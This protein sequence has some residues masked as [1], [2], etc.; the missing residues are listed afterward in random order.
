MIDVK[1]IRERKIVQAAIAYSAA[2][3]ALLQV[4]EFLSGTYGWPPA[5]LRG[6]PVL[7]VAG[8][9]IVIVLAWF[10]GERGQQRVTT[11][12]A[13]I[14]AAL[15]FIG[16]G[17]S[18]L[19]G[20]GG[21]K[22]EIP[23]VMMMD[24]PAPERVYDVETAEFNGTNA[25]VISDILLDLPIQRQKEAIGAGWH[26]DEDIRRFEPDLVIIHLSAFCPKAP[27]EEFLGRFRQFVEAFGES[28]T[29]FLVY[30]RGPD[31]WGATCAA[32]RSCE[33]R[34]RTYVDSVFAG[35]YR[36]YPTLERRIHVFGIRDYGE[37]RWHN[38]AVSSAFKLRVRRLLELK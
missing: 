6:A 38:P 28:D 8:L 19:V 37:P 36:E 4:L 5:I 10:H 14:L 27:C 9:F 29:E 33:R 30:S 24:S 23:L 17:G 3:W 1:R 2:G 26:R 16:L 25:D 11:A 13:S 20:R 15:L 18:V 34:L 12:E 22:H 31:P 35:S 7:L 21:N 32:D